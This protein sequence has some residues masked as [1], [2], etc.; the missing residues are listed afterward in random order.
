[1]GIW[2]E[3]EQ[4]TIEY[5]WMLLGWTINR[6]YSDYSTNHTSLLS[7]QLCNIQICLFFIHMRSS[8]AGPGYTWRVGRAFLVPA[9]HFNNHKSGCC[10]NCASQQNGCKIEH[11]E[12][13]PKNVSIGLDALAIVNHS[14]RLQNENRHMGAT[15]GNK[16]ACMSR[17]T[18]QH[19]YVVARTSGT[20]PQSVIVDTAVS[21][22]VSNK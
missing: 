13:M 7:N 21:E 8:C 6:A 2:H 10:S 22:Q 5:F 15:T 17:V 11:I 4:P 3:S 20:P 1:M 9:H 18:F 19:S 14:E 16:M 12:H